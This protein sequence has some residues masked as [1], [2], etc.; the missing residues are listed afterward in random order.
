VTGGRLA[1]RNRAGQ[2]VAGCREQR[3]GEGHG[4]DLGRSWHKDQALTLLLRQA[5]GAHTI[6][7]AHL[8]HTRTR[9][10]GEDRGQG[11]VSALR[12]FAGWLGLAADV[13]LPTMA[14]HRHR[15]AC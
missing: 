15:R 11:L 1:F 9:G 3:R 4:A 5:V 2:H 14:G 7:D 13:G 8:R 10:G 6:G 12:L